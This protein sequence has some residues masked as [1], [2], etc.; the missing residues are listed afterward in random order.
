MEDD[1]ILYVLQVSQ[2]T[3]RYLAVWG[4]DRNKSVLNIIK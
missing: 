1:F 4:T 3:D 2:Y